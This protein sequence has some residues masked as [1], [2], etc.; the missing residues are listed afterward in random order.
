[1]HTH[2]INSDFIYINKHVVKYK[3]YFIYRQETQNQKYIYTVQ[4]TL[5]Y[6]WLAY[7]IPP[8]TC[9]PNCKYE[10]SGHR[11]SFHKVREWLT[12]YWEEMME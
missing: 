12:I 4:L 7:K 11:I 8:T 1:M 2:N 9:G 6:T 10:L 3:T 5:V